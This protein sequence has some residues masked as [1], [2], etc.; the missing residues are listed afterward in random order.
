MQVAAEDTLKVIRIV[1][2]WLKDTK[3]S[4]KHTQ[5]N[6][7]VDQTQDVTISGDQISFS[8]SPVFTENMFIHIGNW[9]AVLYPRSAK[10]KQTTIETSKTHMTIVVKNKSGE[11][12][13]VFAP[14]E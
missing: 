1:R 10:D 5:N 2:G 6:G 9:T 11:E 3:V 7:D 8:R 14:M 12:T 13:W 4:V